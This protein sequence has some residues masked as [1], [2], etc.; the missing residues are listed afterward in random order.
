MKGERII[1]KLLFELLTSPLGLPIKWYYEYIIMFVIGKIAFSYGWEKSPGGPFGSIIH[2]FYRTIAFFVL[3]A[4]AYGGIYAYK[5]VH[6]N[7]IMIVLYI[8]AIV[9]IGLVYKGIKSCVA[10]MKSY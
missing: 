2:Y 7:P 1:N 4:I 9:V 8:I 10:I 5:Q 6:D 3:W